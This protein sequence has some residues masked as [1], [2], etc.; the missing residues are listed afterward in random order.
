MTKRSDK[1]MKEADYF[2]LKRPLRSYYNTRIDASYKSIRK[3]HLLVFIGNHEV[4]FR[5]PVN[6]TLSVHHH[7][8]FSMNINV[9]VKDQVAYENQL[10]IYITTSKSM[11]TRSLCHHLS[12]LSGLDNEKFFTNEIFE[13]VRRYDYV[14]N[15]NFERVMKMLHADQEKTHS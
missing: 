13:E 2:Y 9:T 5:F 8:S 12:N 10:W 11:Q 1:S 14:R 4:Q 3:K 15:N 6:F 7:S